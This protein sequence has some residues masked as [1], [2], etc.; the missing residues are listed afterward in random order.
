MRSASGGCVSN[1][2]LV[3]A[4]RALAFDVRA[5]STSQRCAVARDTWC[6]TVWSA[7]SFS[8]ARATRR[9]TR[10]RPR[11]CRRALRG[12]ARS[13]TT[14]CGR[15]TRGCRR[16]PRPRSAASAPPSLLSSSPQSAKND[17]AGRDL[18]DHDE[19]A[20]GRDRERGHLHVAVADV[21]QLVGEHAFELA[22]RH[23]VEQAAR[24]RD[25]GVVRA[26]GRT[27]TRSGRGRRRCTPSASAA[28]SRCTGPR[29]RCAAPAPAPASLRPPGSARSWRAPRRA[30]RSRST[31]IATTTPIATPR[32]GDR[33]TRSPIAPPST[34]DEQELDREHHQARPPVLGDQIV[35]RDGIGVGHGTHRTAPPDRCRSGTRCP[36][37]GPHSYDRR[38]I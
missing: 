18:G 37:P 7:S 29:S 30:R 16:A 2:R 12:D 5:A 21:R 8:S 17:R 19:Q 24:D 6:S 25:A 10:S 32:R 23:E 33:V 27:R 26:T 15:R 4:W 28:R 9:A 14:A 38:A 31:T 13:R 22:A 3:L 1:R 11:S 20:D 36:A 34:P 35:M